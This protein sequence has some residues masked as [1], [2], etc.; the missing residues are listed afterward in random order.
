MPIVLFVFTQLDFVQNAEGWFIEGLTSWDLGKKDIVADIF[1]PIW[2]VSIV[3]VAALE[4]RMLRYYPDA[5]NPPDATPV[6]ILTEARVHASTWVATAG[7]GAIVIM[8]WTR[9]WVR[10]SE[11]PD[12]FWYVLTI[13]FVFVMLFIPV[14]WERR[15]LFGD[16]HDA[17]AQSKAAHRIDVYLFGSDDGKGQRWLVLFTFAALTAFVVFTTLNQFD[18]LLKGMHRSG[19]ASVG[20]NGLASVFELDLSQKPIQII[21]R[22]GSWAEYAIEVGPGFAT[23]YAVAT[24][25][26]LLDSLVMIPAYTICIGILLLHA[27]RTPPES[28]DDASRGSYS[29]V[30]GVGFLA[31]GVLVIS[32]LVENLMTWVVIDSAWYTPETLGSWTV[33]LMWFGSLFRTFAVFLLVAV[34][35]LSLAFRVSRYRWLGDAIVSVRGQ[36]LVVV[37]VAAV[38]GMAQMEDVVRRWTVSVAFLTVAMA[39]ALAVLVEWTSASAL[40]RLRIERSAAES[41]PP[42]NCRACGSGYPLD[43][44]YSKRG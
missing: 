15:N 36:I 12:A 44:C 34:A 40:N 2:V 23:G 33:R 27:R 42:G 25:Y 7:A 10:F 18:A 37:L 31:L 17:I 38:L 20:M 21:E 4:R 9:E 1:A 26:L 13:L 14:W 28:L 11:Q 29:L 32:D 41:G 8:S 5:P 16:I 24:G 3:V 35:V 43:P 6:P 30:N 22:V 39:T 19:G